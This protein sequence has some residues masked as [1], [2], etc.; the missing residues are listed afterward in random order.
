MYK[1]RKLEVGW[2][3]MMCDCNGHRGSIW[4]DGDSLELGC[5]DSWTALKII[6]AHLESVNS[7]VCKSYLHKIISPGRLKLS[8]SW[9]GC[10][11]RTL[12]K[13]G[14]NTPWVKGAIYGLK[15]LSL[16]SQ[17]TEARQANQSP[18]SIA[19]TQFFPWVHALPLCPVTLA[20]AP[21]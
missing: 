18:R 21:S 15:Q 13:W 3:R 6:E 2:C 9:N 11:L 16:I 10:S 4:G 14:L 12:D 7:R 8:P 19:L 1:K 20:E 17:I 5:A